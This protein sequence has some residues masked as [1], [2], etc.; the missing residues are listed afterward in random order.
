MILEILKKKNN[1]GGMDMAMS[2]MIS[3]EH[4]NS[5]FKHPKWFSLH[6][7]L[8]VKFPGKLENATTY[9]I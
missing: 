3:W 1:K 7:Y 6:K 4:V 8:D 5:T 2:H 9:E